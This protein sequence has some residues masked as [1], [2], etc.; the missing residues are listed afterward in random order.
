MPPM[1]YAVVVMIVNRTA[2]CQR[3]NALGYRL[4]S[5]QGDEKSTSLTESEIYI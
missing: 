2:I 4:N 1:L 3:C 5:G